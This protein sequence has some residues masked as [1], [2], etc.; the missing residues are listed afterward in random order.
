M[1]RRN[2]SKLNRLE[3]VKLTHSKL[4]KLL[5]MWLRLRQAVLQI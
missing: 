3:C 2:S 1:R 4:T 5:T